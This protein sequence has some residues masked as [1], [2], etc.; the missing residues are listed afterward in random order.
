MNEFSGKWKQFRGE[1]KRKWGELTDDDLDRADGNWD[2]FVGTLQERYGKTQD[3]SDKE[4]RKFFD[5]LT[6]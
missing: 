2:K 1:I 5:G 4:A 6:G 3:Q